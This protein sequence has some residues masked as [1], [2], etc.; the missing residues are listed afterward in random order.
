MKMRTKKIAIGLLT[1]SVTGTAVGTGCPPVVDSVWQAAM[2]AAST[3]IS[4]EIMAL[5]ESVSAART[6]NLMRI[7]S[8]IRVT[9][10]QI[11]TSGEKQA[12]TEVATKQAGANFMVELSNRKAILETTMEYNAATGQGFDPCGEMR[13]SQNIAVAVGE[14]NSGMPDRVMREIDSA[15]GRLVSNQAEVVSKRL[16][17]GRTLYCSADQVKAGVCPQAGQLAGKDVDA[18]HFFTTYQ[19]GT[20]EAQAKSA[21]L[22]NMYGIPYAAPDKSAVNTP[23]G[24]AFFEAKRT[25]DGYR[26]VSQASMKTLQAWT[27]SRPGSGDGS[28]SVLGSVAAKVGTYSG[29]NNY[30]E[31]EQKKASESEHGLLVEL[32]KMRAFE[33]YMRNLE[34]QQLER[35]EANIAAMLALRARS[36]GDGSVASERA[37]QRQ[38]VQ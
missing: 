28:D 12:A 20:P 25:E 29:G 14:A 19:L 18:G 7:Q 24:K 37:A 17:D 21:L 11:E 3:T 32:A 2:T 13:R 34:Y 15:P 8:A 35:Q 9:A 1:L 26:S 5:V 31:W 33:L 38:K 6:A 16:A 4:A 36:G 10:K 27:E 30:A 22:N 23:S